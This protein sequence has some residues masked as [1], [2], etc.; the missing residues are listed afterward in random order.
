MPKAESLTHLEK[1][2]NL[3]AA[4]AM[5]GRTQKEQIRFLDRAG[6][7]QTEIAT[8]VESTPKAVSVRLAEI[9]HGKKKVKK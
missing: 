8:I 4:V 2:L 5:D 1:T 6:F 9:R 7:K 3:L